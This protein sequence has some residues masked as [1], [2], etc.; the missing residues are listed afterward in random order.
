MLSEKDLKL[1]SLLG[2]NARMPVSELA[3]HLNV[4]RT[5]AQA[6]LEK[7]ERNGVIAGYGVHLGKGFADN[8]VK[9]YVM[10]KSPPSTRAGV[11]VQLKQIVSLS[12]LYSISGAFDLVAVLAAQ[13]VGDLDKVIDQIGTIDG[14]SETMS[15]IILSTKVDR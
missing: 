8:L 5:A 9:A 15:S 3:R 1:I 7:L 12:K 13:S 4:S 2:E 14:V 11:E 10:I 6:R